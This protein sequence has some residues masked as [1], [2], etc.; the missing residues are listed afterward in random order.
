[1]L[2]NEAGRKAETSAPRV[3]VII[4]VKNEAD[5]VDGLVADLAAQD[6]VEPFEVVVADGRSTDQ[7]VELLEAAAGREGL[8]LT[9]VDNPQ[10][11]QSPGLNLCISH[12][13]GDILVRLDAH[14]KYPADYVRHC[15]EAV[16]ETGAWNASGVFTPIGRTPMERAVACALD[17]PFGGHNWTRK[18]A[19]N[20][21]VE[22]DTNY[23]GAFPRQALE[24][25]G[26]YD[27]DLF[28]GE[29]EDV[30]LSLRKAGG[31]VILDPA[32]RSYYYP[33]GSFGALFLQYFRYGYWKLAVMR[34]HRAL[35]SGR[36]VVPAAFV[37]LLL[38]LAVAATVSSV[39]RI[40][41]AAIVGLYGLSAL[42]FGIEA[43]RRR[44]ESFRLLPRVV[45]VFPTFHLSHGLGMIVSAFGYI[46]G[47]KPVAP[48]P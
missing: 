5:Y 31:R 9:V 18:L 1:M 16:R 36:S 11:F 34:K 21:R 28:V 37:L 41:L 26:G 12:S 43:V 32:I 33:R 25:V 20:V 10:G 42:A 38:G 2:D 45:G 7:T 27:E 17:S 19:E 15:V 4:P 3:S 46:I 8:R 44:G 48:R 23:L 13:V 39:A 22:V 24:R 6:L 14:T 47:R 35:I 40:A 29:V 30:N